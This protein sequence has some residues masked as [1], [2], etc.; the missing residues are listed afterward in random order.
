MGGLRS[1]TAFPKCF[2]FEV[3]RGCM[4]TGEEKMLVRKGSR[5]FT[6]RTNVSNDTHRRNR[7]ECGSSTMCVALAAGLSNECC[8]QCTDEGVC[9]V[10]QKRSV[11]LSSQSI[12]R[13]SVSSSVC[14][15]CLSLYPS[16]VCALKVPEETN[17]I[18]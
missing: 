7:A 1:Q 2:C 9:K 8:M 4:R 5:H 13:L 10:R 12:I 15:E 18:T 11:T 6:T 17:F 3:A 14:C 16:P